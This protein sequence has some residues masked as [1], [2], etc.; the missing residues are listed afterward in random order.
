MVDRS[1]SY[2]TVFFMAALTSMATPQGGNPL[3][4]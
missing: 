4:A 1:S 2:S 3:A